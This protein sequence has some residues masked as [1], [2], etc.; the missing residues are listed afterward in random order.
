M[1]YTLLVFVHLLAAC[2]ALGAIVATDLRM[3]SRLAH[4]RVRIPPPNGFVARIVTI[5]LALLWTTGGAIVWLGLEGNPGFVTPKLAAKVALVVLLTLNA[6]VLHRLT[7][8]RLARGRRVGR[9]DFADYAIVAPPVALS[10]CLWL[11]C[12]FLGIARPWNRTTTIVE[13]VEIAAV[14]YAATLVIVIAVLAIAGLREPRGWLGACLLTTKR[15]LGA[16]GRLG[17]TGD[18][19]G[20]M[21]APPRRSPDRRTQPPERTEPSL[22]SALPPSIMLLD[23]YRR[24]REGRRRA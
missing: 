21:D 24:A 20:Y 10:N 18:D 2:M 8:P 22:P 4:D 11:F 12:A 16:I 19:A 6:W 14:L 5:G 13:I 23:A 15:W 9:W 1:T 7:F 3:L 17:E